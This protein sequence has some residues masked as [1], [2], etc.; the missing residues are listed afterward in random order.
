MIYFLIPRTYNDNLSLFLNC[1]IS[2]DSS[3]PKPTI[4]ESLSYYL[5]DI[6]EK[7]QKYDQ[8]WDQYKKY[9]NP[10]EY[11]HSNLPNR[12]KSVSKYKPL[13]RSFFKMIEVVETF[14][15]IPIS[16]TEQPINT[17]HLAEGPGGFIEAIARIRNMPTDTYIGMTIQT[18]GPNEDVPAWKKSTRFLRETPQ[19]I[20]ENGSDGSGD[21]LRIEN[22]VHC[23]HKYASSMDFIT[24]DGGFDFSTD[25][26]NQ[27]VH[28]GRLL[29]AQIAYALVL[30]RKGGSFVLKVFDI[31]MSHTVDLIYLL[32]SMYEKVYVTKPL[33][34]RFANSEKYIVCQ[35]FLPDSSTP[36]YPVL[37]STFC[38][39][40]A[41]PNN[42]FIVRYLSCDIPLHFIS[43]V[44]ECNASIGQ[45]Q[46]E[47]IHQTISLIN[48]YKNRERIDQLV[49]TNV[50]KCIEWCTHHH[51]DYYRDFPIQ[52][53][54]IVNIRV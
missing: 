28:I 46:I 1:I 36:F 3:M 48:M 42:Q 11:I 45:Q 5:S 34:S 54:P 30:Q 27:E 49:R 8:E 29:F 14:K 26:N 53:P 6:K 24:G 52:Q 7:I 50:Q 40:N 9:T 15:L 19:V 13:S 16:K 33:T 51:I 4:S 12:R 32:S 35:N 20:I 43:R 2:R 17:F 41:L 21:I 18:S 47:T 23:Y 10:Y 25:F 39:M 22:F 31:F 37:Y 38:Y 44:E